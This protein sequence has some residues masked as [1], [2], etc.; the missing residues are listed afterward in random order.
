M[1][2][3]QEVEAVVLDIVDDLIQDWGLEL[4]EPVGS[5]TK[6]VAHL[7]F[8]SVDLIQ[9]CVAIEEH[10]ERRLEF[11]DL[12]MVDGNYVEDVTLNQIGEFVANRLR[13][14]AV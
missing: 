14:D 12:L 1:E 10:Y 13:K 4:D 8:A 11:R 9:L 6:L 2:K 3:S 5:S 7:D